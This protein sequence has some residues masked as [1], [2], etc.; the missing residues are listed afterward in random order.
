VQLRITKRISP[1]DAPLGADLPVA[2][3]RHSVYTYANGGP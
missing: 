3:T 1:S 2:L